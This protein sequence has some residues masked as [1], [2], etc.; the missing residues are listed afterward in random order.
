MITD[1]SKFC[2]T[3]LI[4]QPDFVTEEV[5]EWAKEV[6]L[7][8]KPRQIPPTYVCSRYKEGVCAQV[9]HIGPYDDE[10]E[11]IEKLGALLKQMVMRR[12]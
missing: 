3:S 10:P 4:R 5:L 6:C 12:R 2:W 11:T 7:A 9:M 8:K 1:K